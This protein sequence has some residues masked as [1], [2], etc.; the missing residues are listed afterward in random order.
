MDGYGGGNEFFS[1]LEEERKATAKTRER[2]SEFCDFFLKS[3][4]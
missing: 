1:W 4:K 3:T 2:R